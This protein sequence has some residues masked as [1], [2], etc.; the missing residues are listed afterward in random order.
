MTTTIGNTTFGRN[1]PGWAILIT[2]LATATVL[3][4]VGIWELT[5]SESTT[6]P[7][8]PAVVSRPFVP[9]AP[10][11]Q[12]YVYLVDSEA[13]KT[14]ILLADYE[15]Q[16]GA[17]VDGTSFHNTEVLDI[18]TPSGQEAYRLMNAELAQVAMEAPDYVSNVQFVDLT[19]QSAAAVP[20]AAVPVDLEIDR[21]AVPTFFYVVDSQEQI[22][23]VMEAEVISS[24]EAMLVE[25]PQLHHTVIVDVST[26]E[27]VQLL[28]TVNGDLHQIWAETGFDNGLIQII[29]FRK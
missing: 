21:P 28:N 23:L 26:P 5:K 3:A 18:S 7:A 12:T 22:D 15:A 16:L 8:E 4:G 13:Q 25:E 1:K 6:A 20:S 10:A 29:D 9:S 27:G 11:M 17:G 24:Q 2:G 14:A 19:R